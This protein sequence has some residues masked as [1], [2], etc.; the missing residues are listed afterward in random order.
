MLNKVAGY[1]TCFHGFG[2]L[3]GPIMAGFVMFYFGFPKVMEIMGLIMVGLGVTDIVFIVKERQA[4]R[5]YAEP[6]RSCE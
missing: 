1:R 6:Q 5:R 2:L 3:L 4:G